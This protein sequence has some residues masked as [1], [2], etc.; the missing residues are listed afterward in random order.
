MSVPGSVDSGNSPGLFSSLRSF[1]RV[2]ISI[3]YTRLDLLTIELEEEAKRAIQLVM[4]S[5]A[6]LLCVSMAVFFLMFFLIALFWENRLI[7][8]GIVF[9][10]YLIASVVLL[11]IARSMILSRPKFLS[12]TLA[13]LR[14]DAESLRPPPVTK[15]EEV[16]S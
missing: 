10:F 8:L 3:L 14:R 11:F 15:T 1:W 4:V 5:V 6:G 16:K 2:L 12:H 13:E 9:G 7:V